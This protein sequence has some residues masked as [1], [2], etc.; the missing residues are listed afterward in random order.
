MIESTL[1][2]VSIGAAL[3]AVTSAATFGLAAAVVRAA[4]SWIERREGVGGT[5]RPEGRELRSDIEALV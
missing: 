2:S 1:V 4:R 3:G 5:D